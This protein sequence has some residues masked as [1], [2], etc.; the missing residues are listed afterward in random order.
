MRLRLGDKM[1]RAEKPSPSGRGR[2]EGRG[3][4]GPN[5]SPGEKKRRCAPLKSGEAERDQVGEGQPAGTS[6]HRPAHPGYSSSASSAFLGP[7]LA[8]RRPHKPS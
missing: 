2:T 5:C 1:E 3:L 6:P 7:W 8:Q 4:A